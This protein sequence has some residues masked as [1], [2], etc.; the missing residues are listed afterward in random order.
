MFYDGYKLLNMPDADNTRPE[1]Y[2]SEGNR[3]TG[4][5]TF[6]NSYAVKRF[7]RHSE[8]FCIIVRTRDELSGIADKFFNDIKKLYFPASEM[9]QE[10]RAHGL[11]VELYLN[12]NPCGY[13]IPLSAANKIKKFSHLLNDTALMIFDEFQTEDNKYLTDEVNK[14]LS[15]HTSLAREIGRSVKRLPIIMIANQ[16]SLINPYYLRLGISERIKR[17]TKF[18]RGSGYVL[19]RNFKSDIAALQAGSGFNRAFSMTDYFKNLTENVYLNDN[20]TFIETLSGRNKYICTVIKNGES[21]SIREYPDKNILYCDSSFDESFKLRIAIDA[22][23]QSD[24]NVLRN[25]YPT[26]LSTFKLYFQS[27]KFRFKNAACKSCVF[28]LLSY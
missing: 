8:K 17:N 28:S 7:L 5:T 26:L 13:A 12:G 15:V 10:S 18:L 16:V 23:S 2:I 20:Q 22:I 27:G 9:L 11:Y 19:E 21:F 3:S 4:K 24:D 6:F 25:L 14:L 1:I